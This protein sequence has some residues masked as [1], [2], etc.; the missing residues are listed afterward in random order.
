MSNLIYQLF[1]EFCSSFEKENIL[2][3]SG[4]VD[5]NDSF[6]YINIVF[7]G[8]ITMLNFDNVFRFIAHLNKSS[9]KLS[10]KLCIIIEFI[11]INDD[12]EESK[13]N[14]KM[15]SKNITPTNYGFIGTQTLNY[16]KITAT[17][18]KLLKRNKWLNNIDFVDNYNYNDKYLIV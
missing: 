7:K 5:K 16:Y 2:T 15:L 3:I 11:N 4:V 8:E 10:K 12:G 9:F 18:K 13:K 6:D 17:N 1:S 14:K